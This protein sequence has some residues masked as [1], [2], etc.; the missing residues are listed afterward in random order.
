MSIYVYL[1]HLLSFAIRWIFSIMDSFELH[2]VLVILWFLL[3]S[4]MATLLGAALFLK[5]LI[6]DCF[7]FL[8]KW[9]RYYMKGPAEE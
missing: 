3:F 9:V 8:V 4:E 6:D 7:F 1:Y 2:S 5:N